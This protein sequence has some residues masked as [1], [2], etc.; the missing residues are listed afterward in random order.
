MSD[1][2][3]IAGRTSPNVDWATR[4]PDVPYPWTVSPG[5]ITAR[6]RSGMRTV[7]RIRRGPATPISPAAIRLIVERAASLIAELEAAAWE[8]MPDGTATALAFGN[9]RNAVTGEHGIIARRWLG[10]G[11]YSGP[12]AELL[13]PS[14][15]IDDLARQS[16]NGLCGAA[17]NGRLQIYVCEERNEA[18]P[19]PAVFAAIDKPDDTT[20]VRLLARLLVDPFEA[21]QWADPLAEGEGQAVH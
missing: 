3:R 10:G 19:R 8:T 9:S 4:P 5:T 20:R 16:A 11:V 17:A 21:E 15:D 1:S 6:V 2:R 13:A 7:D 12:L 18:N 14:G